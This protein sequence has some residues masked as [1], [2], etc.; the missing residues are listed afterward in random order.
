MAQ[1]LTQSFE[2]SETPKDDSDQSKPGPQRKHLLVVPDQCMRQ[3]V[4]SMDA[5]LTFRRDNHPW[6][7]RVSSAPPLTALRYGRRLRGMTDEFDDLLDKRM[8]RMRTRTF[9]M[10]LSFLWRYKE[11]DAERSH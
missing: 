9:P 10:F 3:R 1:K 2:V 8:K 5:V 7:A 11:S 6:R 4:Q